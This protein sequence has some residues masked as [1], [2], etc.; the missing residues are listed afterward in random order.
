M[1]SFGSIF[2]NSYGGYGGGMMGGFGLPFPGLVFILVLAWSL[3]WKGMALWRAA[4]LNQRE[5]FVA[6]LLINTLGILDIVYLYIISVDK[7]NK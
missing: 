2:T 7:K 1:E 5:W 6:L 4:R 3:V